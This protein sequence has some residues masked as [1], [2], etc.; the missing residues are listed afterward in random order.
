[1]S[2]ENEWDR[3]TNEEQEL[4]MDANRILFDFLEPENNIEDSN[5]FTPA[6]LPND[7]LEENFDW[8]AHNSSIPY[9]WIA[10]K[11]Y[12]VCHNCGLVTYATGQSIR[13][14]K[15]CNYCLSRNL[16]VVRAGEIS[17]ALRNENYGKHMQEVF[18]ER[19]DRLRRTRT[20]RSR[21]RRLS[22]RTT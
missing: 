5:Y 16:H 12:M 19:Q 3:D 13:E 15:K 21:R 2:H 10:N 9:H 18:N 22:Q 11:I 7:I 4:E 20:E 8:I 1:M 17:M 14:L 6:V